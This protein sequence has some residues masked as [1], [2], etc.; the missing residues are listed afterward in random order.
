VLGAV[1]AALDLPHLREPRFQEGAI[2]F[3]LA[4]D[5]LARPSSA[6]SPAT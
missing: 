2:D 3:T 1:A 5:V 4:G 6:S